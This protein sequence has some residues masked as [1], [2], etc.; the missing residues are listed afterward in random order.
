M[1][2]SMLDA[3]TTIAR[4]LTA[5]DHE[6]EHELADLRGRAGPTEQVACARGCA[7]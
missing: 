7:A 6:I 4:V 3:T 5:L 2:T 1:T